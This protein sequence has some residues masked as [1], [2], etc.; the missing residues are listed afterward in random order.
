M[1]TANSKTRG[2]H[3]MII[4][5]PWAP[6]IIKVRQPP[7]FGQRA[8]RLRKYKGVSIP[9]PNWSRAHSCCQKAGCPCRWPPP[10]KC[11]PHV[12]LSSGGQTLPET[13]WALPRSVICF[14]KKSSKWGLINLRVCDTEGKLHSKGTFFWRGRDREFGIAMYTLLY[15]KWIT[16]K[17]LLYRTGNSAQHYSAAWMGGEFGGEWIHVYA[18][19]S[20]SAVTWNYYNTVNQLYSKEKKNVKKK[21]IG[22]Q[23]K[24]KNISFSLW[25]TMLKMRPL[26][27]KRGSY[28]LIGKPLL[29]ISQEL[30][31]NYLETFI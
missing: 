23:K 30:N 20:P 19:L 25:S 21:N 2:L 9:V 11:Q 1:Q 12:I 26:C 22:L 24:Q 6:Q 10:S 31:W 8:A 13:K 27:L 4:F 16:N 18:C 15:L 7:C 5:L 29:F 28:L 3:K 14:E 17:V